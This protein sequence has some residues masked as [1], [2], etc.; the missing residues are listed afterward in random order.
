VEKITEPFCCYA[1]RLIFRP[2]AN[3]N[4]RDRFRREFIVG[5]NSLAH[6]YQGPVERLTIS[7][8]VTLSST[9]AGVTEVSPRGNNGILL[10]H[11]ED[12]IL[13]ITEVPS[14]E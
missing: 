11:L 6:R 1:N 9:E 12:G 10:V 14:Y 4:E 7:G 13:I 2:T 8:A 3:F 5:I